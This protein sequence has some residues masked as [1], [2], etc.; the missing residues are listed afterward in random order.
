MKSACSRVLAALAL[1]LLTSS[2]APA[3]PKPN[4]PKKGENSPIAAEARHYRIVT[5]PIPTDVVLE[6][7]GLGFRPDG[8]LL[9]CTRRGE[10]W[11]VANPDAEEPAQIKY[12]LFAT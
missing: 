11:L 3:A 10:V 12:K 6:V 5:L 2:A 1:A 9:A 4:D 8:K 7:G